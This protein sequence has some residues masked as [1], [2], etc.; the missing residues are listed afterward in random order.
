MLLSML[1]TAGLL[2]FL[3]GLEALMLVLLALFLPMLTGGVRASISSASSSSL[4]DQY[5]YFDQE[6]MR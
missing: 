2:D 4:W 3:L 1:L 5:G 6:Q